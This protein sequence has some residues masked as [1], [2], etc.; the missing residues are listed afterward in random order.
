[1]AN[2]ALEKF[3]MELLEVPEKHVHPPEPEKPKTEKPKT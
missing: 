2:W 1:M 3:K